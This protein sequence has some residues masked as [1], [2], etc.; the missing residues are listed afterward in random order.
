VCRRPYGRIY[1]IGGSNRLGARLSTVEACDPATNT[2]TFVEAMPTLLWDLAGATASV[3]IVARIFTF[4]GH[5]EL[6][7]FN[8]VQAYTP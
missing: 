7:P 8:L 4:G 5:A 2:W 3:R 6:P 1:A